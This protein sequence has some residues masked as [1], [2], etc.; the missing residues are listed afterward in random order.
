MDTMS[1][2]IAS[3]KKLKKHYGNTQQ[4]DLVKNNCPVCWQSI[5]EGYMHERC[6]KE[7]EQE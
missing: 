5:D 6:A 1:L 4:K 7:L 2:V 3:L